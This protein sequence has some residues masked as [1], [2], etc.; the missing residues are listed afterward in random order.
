[1][2]QIKDIISNK[3]MMWII[4]ILF[5]SVV[6]N[7]FLLCDGRK[8]KT[9]VKTETKTVYDTVKHI[10]PVAKDSLIVKYKYKVLPVFKNIT[11]DSVPYIAHT[12]TNDS[13][14]VIIP[15]TQKIYADSNYTAYISGFEPT[16]DSIFIKNK[17]TTITN[18]ITKTKKKHFGIGV[19]IGY[20]YGIKS[21]SFEPYL[22]IGLQYSIY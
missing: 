3:A 16:L 15:I 10:A 11:G 17:T 1:M 5:A 6:L 19:N 8:E 2:R 7:V 12:A 4:G 13:A 20:G 9:K 18:T 14:G 21:K 22:G